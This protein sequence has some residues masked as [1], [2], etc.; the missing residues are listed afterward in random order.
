MQQHGQG[1]SEGLSDAH[2]TQEPAEQLVALRLAQP[3]SSQ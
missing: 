3:A 2:G 1:V